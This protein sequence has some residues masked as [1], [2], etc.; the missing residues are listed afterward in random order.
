[1]CLEEERDESKMTTSGE[2][3]IEKKNR[4]WNWR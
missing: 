2:R 3:P 1:M 4:R